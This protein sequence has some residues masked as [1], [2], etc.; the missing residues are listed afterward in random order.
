MLTLIFYFIH[1]FYTVEDIRS[2]ISELNGLT[3]QI[4]DGTQAREAA[5]V[6]AL[7]VSEKFYDLCGDVMSNLRDLKDNIYSQE[8]PG[9]DAQTI[10]EQQKELKV[11]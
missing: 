11:A 4:Q 5:L 8:P 10:K 6:E 7:G 1:L 3:N 2:K 9:V